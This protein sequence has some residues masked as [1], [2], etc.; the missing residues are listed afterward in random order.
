MTKMTLVAA[1]ALCLLG[2]VAGADEAPTAA[3]R[4]GWGGYDSQRLI[5]GCYDN[6]RG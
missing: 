3:R 1:A 4:A 6:F 2:G 5:L